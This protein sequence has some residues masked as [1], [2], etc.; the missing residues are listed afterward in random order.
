MGLHVKTT[1]FKS[2]SLGVVTR[3]AVAGQ[4]RLNLFAETY[5]ACRRIIATAEKV[6]YD[7]Q[8]EN[9]GDFFHYLYTCVKGLAAQECRFL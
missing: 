7:T 1:F 4:N 8:A 9:F 5:F 2:F 6:E 3:Q